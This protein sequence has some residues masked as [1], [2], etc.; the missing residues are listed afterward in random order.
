VKQLLMLASGR[1]SGRTAQFR[2]K[3]YPVLELT[4]SSFEGIDIGLFSAGGSISAKFAPFAT[5]ADCIVI[6]NTAHFRM[7]PDVP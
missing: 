3:D 1:S 7:D 6:D 5:K 4:E 2:G